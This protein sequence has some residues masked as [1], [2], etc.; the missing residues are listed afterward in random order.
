MDDYRS[1]SV[2][3]L[4]TLMMLFEQTSLIHDNGHILATQQPFPSPFLALNLLTYFDDVES[5][6]P[7]KF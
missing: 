5:L 6:E 1:T 2:I 3:L 7:S 4:A